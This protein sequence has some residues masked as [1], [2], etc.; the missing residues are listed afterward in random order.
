MF[1]TRNG[2]PDCCNSDNDHAFSKEVCHD[3]IRTARVIIFPLE[4]ERSFAFFP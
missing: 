1:Q 4:S 3:Q 2:N